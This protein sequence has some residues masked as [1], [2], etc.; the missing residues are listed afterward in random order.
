MDE[1]LET[2]DGK[3]LVVVGP[4][5]ALIPTEWIALGARLVCTE[6]REPDYWWAYRFDDH[7]YDWFAEYDDR[8]Y[9]W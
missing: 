1:L 4:S 7:L 5:G 6:L 9:I 2:L 8:V 3:P